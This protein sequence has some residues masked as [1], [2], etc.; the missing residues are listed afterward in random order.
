MHRI[1]G[2]VDRLLM[3]GKGG[4][5]RRLR[6]RKKG[7]GREGVKGGGR[8]RGRVCNSSPHPLHTDGGVRSCIQA[9]GG[10]RWRDREEGEREDIQ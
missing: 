1:T 8:G 10:L 3:H 4:G 7:R 5:I 9:E 6:G 2:D